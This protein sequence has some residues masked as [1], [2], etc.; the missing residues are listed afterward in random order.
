M[1]KSEY[2]NTPL[3]SPSLEE[4]LKVLRV[5]RLPEEMA[6]LEGARRRSCFTKRNRRE[7]ITD[8]VSRIKPLPGGCWF[9]IAGKRQG[10]GIAKWFG[11]NRPVHSITKELESGVR[12]PGKIACHKC[13]NKWCVNPS[14]VY[15][16]T[17]KSNTRDA[18][19][20]GRLRPLRGEENPRS[21]LT[22]S[23]VKQMRSRWGQAGV[24][25]RS[26]ALEF[27]VTPRTVR[28][29]VSQGTHWTHIPPAA[30]KLKPR[31]GPSKNKWSMRHAREIRNLRSKG[32]KLREISNKT[33][34]PYD[35]VC[36]IVYNRMWKEALPQRGGR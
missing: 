32:N 14:H 20:R 17:Y 30:I 21:I 3:S 34:V 9:W 5:L 13:D 6:N 26:L 24:T 35:T 29:V 27:G 10:Y 22:D 31:H 19:D 2:P 36:A 1:T 8:L 23:D 33:G 7:S 28:A 18:V 25:R 11:K 12:P 16:G 4:K 15:W